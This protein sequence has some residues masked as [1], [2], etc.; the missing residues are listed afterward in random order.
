MNMT[1]E[2][3]KTTNNTSGKYIKYRAFRDHDSRFARSN[4]GLVG[5]S[6]TQSHEYLCVRLV[7]V[8][9][10]LFVGSGLVMGQSPVQGILPCIGIT[11]LKK[12]PGPNWGLY[13][14]DIVYAGLFG[15]HI[16][17]MDIFLDA[18]FRP[19]PNA[20]VTC[21]HMLRV[22]GFRHECMASEEKGL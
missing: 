5:S 2:E 4:T 21:N 16:T 7:R 6:P 19:R 11:N 1:F 9:V 13:S 20:E 18:G 15:L 14:H 12:R 22:M 8:Y 17:Y 3:Y 10:V